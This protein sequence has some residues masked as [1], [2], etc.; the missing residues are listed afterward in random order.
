MSELDRHLQSLGVFNFAGTDVERARVVMFGAPMD[1]TVSFKPGTR[2][3]PG[4]IREASYGLEEYSPV[5]D[6]HLSEVRV[7]D[8]GDLVLPFGNVEQSLA[9][10]YEQAKRIVEQGKIPF[11]LGGEHL[12]TLPVVTAVAE[13]YPD[14]VLVHFDAHTD[15]RDTFFGESRSHATVIRRC[16]ERLGAGRIYQYGIRSGE[17]HEFQYAETMTVMRRYGVTELTRDMA[18]FADRPVYITFDIDV[19]DPAF[20]PGTGTPEPDGITVRDAFDALRS[21]AGLNVVGMDVVE[22]SPPYDPSGT[23]A[24]T[25]A[26]IVREALV[27]YWWE[28]PGPARAREDALAG[29]DRANVIRS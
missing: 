23:T 9:I 4:R 13:R 16:A 17:R 6:R 28:G 12:I 20:C 14:L 8:I 29:R 27:A 15:L 21:L 5:Y 26:K 18:R 11:V 7:A 22:V 24:I 19:I 3:G 2:F 1:W 25:A 10:I